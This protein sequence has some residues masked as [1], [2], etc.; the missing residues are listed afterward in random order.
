[1]LDGGLILHYANLSITG[2]QRSHA[3]PVM[4]CSVE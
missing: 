3:V 4:P 2:A 1:M